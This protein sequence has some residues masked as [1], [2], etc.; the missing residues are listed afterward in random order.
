[1]NLLNQ[2]LASIKRQKAI[3]QKKLDETSEPQEQWDLSRK[4]MELDT[5]ESKILKELGV[6]IDSDN[7]Q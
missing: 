7:R 6:K 1:M 2:Q 3:Y 5:E 4:I